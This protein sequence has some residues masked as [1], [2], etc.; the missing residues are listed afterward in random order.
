[1]HALYLKFLCWLE[2]STYRQRFSFVISLYLI[3]VLVMGY[4]MIKS[5]NEDLD[6]ERLE[7]LGTQYLRPMRKVVE[8][9]NRHRLL[10]A[11]PMPNVDI[12]ELNAEIDAD[13]ASLI[14][15]D[16]MLEKQLQTQA[17]DFKAREVSNL[18]PSAL[19]KAW[20][21]SKDV[22]A[23]SENAIQIYLL[24]NLNYLMWYIGETSR[25]FFN[26]HLDVF[27][28]SHVLYTELPKIQQ[29]VYDMG[30][31]VAKHVQNEIPFEEEIGAL[32][33]ISKQIKEQFIF[34]RRDLERAFT[35]N[36]KSEHNFELEGKLLP[37]LE[38]YQT[39]VQ[40][41]TNYLKKN[42]YESK[43]IDEKQYQEFLYLLQKATNS[44]T[45]L[46]ND[47]I[48]QLDVLLKSEIN[49][50]FW[51]QWK[52]LAIAFSIIALAL[53]LGYL[54]IQKITAH[55]RD[56]VAAAK[57]LTSGDLS[58]RLPTNTKGEFKKSAIA[59]NQIVESIQKLVLHF[60][61]AGI[62]LTTSTTEIASAA[63]QQELT[64]LEQEATTKEIAVTAQEITAT[65]KEF[66]KTVN[67]VSLASEKTS[68]LAASGKAGLSQMEMIMRQ[69]VNSS[70]NIAAKL[71]I[72]QEKVS[73]ITN[74]ITTITRV[75]DQTN[76]L[77]LNAA[78]EAEKAGEHGRSFSV[79]AREIRR[80]ADQTGNATLDIEKMVNEMVAAVTAG[81]VGVE[82]F[83]EEI[84]TGVNQ[85]SS[86]S[87]LLSKIIEQVEQQTSSF[88]NVNQGMQS[89]ATGAEQIN[90]SIT[91]LSEI[92]QH[93]AQ[94]IRQFHNAIERLNNAA[95]EMQRA[96]ADVNTVQV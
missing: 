28:L 7:L 73:T 54:L 84:H 72:I 21:E 55:Y 13:F 49:H 30:F 16:Q 48:N 58:T 15:I 87:D 64:V 10:V 33:F 8:Q 91:Q 50:L 25:L 11:H 40:E 93:T 20:Q 39:A 86:V 78:I 85:V 69:M 43:K 32:K 51:Y 59:F 70:N 68:A 63:K 89:Q 23:G 6:L 83:S 19:E 94:S 18:K 2:N 57:K 88:E 92:T 53:I 95:K 66:A 76:L 12:T 61:Q 71:S 45:S 22:Q 52:I 9:I 96:V 60:Q 62:Q 26:P 14:S 5:Q 31:V 1:M 77:S 38:D 79:I 17:N 27:L 41:L 37:L 4:Q 42:V 24:G 90:D 3:A 80:L 29:F 47:T 35:E 74:V 82:S 67:E 36:R 56:I 65:G 44:G 75:A 46:W 81:V 34:L